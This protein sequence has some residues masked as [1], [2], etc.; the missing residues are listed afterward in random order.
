MA[1]ANCDEQAISV[2]LY[3]VASE[4]WTE[5]VYKSDIAAKPDHLFKHDDTA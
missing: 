1:T 2:I 4:D 3:D 5:K